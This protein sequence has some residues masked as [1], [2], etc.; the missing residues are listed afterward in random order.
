[1]VVASALLAALAV[2]LAWP[3]PIALSSA[4]WP[5]RAPALALFVWQSVALAG[6]LSMIGSL[7]TFGLSGIATTVPSGL[8]A[9]AAAVSNGEA[10]DTLGLVHFFALSCAVLFTGHLLLSLLTTF[11]R[12]ERERRRQHDLVALLSSPEPRVPGARVMEYPTP[13]AYCLPGAFRTATVLT[14][15]LVKVL[16]PIE[17]RAVVAHER[18]HLTQQHHLL[19]LAFTAW[20][21]AIP[22][23]PIATRTSAAVALLVEM[24]ADDAARSEVSA[25]PLVSAIVTVATAGSGTGTPDIGVKDSTPES[26][27]PRVSRLLAKP[28]PLPAAVTGGILT[29]SIALVLVPPVLLLAA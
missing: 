10:P 27:A 4:Q 21:K 2:A 15:G 19:L 1:M 8:L 7:V 17:L 29:A 25:E 13:V 22:W 24:L 23:F 26:A 28:H 20:R 16:S 6:A 11:V 3:L 5:R 12:T 14:D 18:A 9:L